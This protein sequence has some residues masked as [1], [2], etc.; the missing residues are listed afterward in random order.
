M[1]IILDEDVNVTVL[2]IDGRLRFHEDLNVTLR[3]NHI[4][5]RKGELLIGEATKPFQ[6]K[7]AIELYGVSSSSGSTRNLL[8]EAGDRALVN[9]GLIEFYGK[10]VANTLTRLQTTAEAGAVTIQV[11]SSEISGWKVGDYIGVAGS[12][13]S[14]D[15]QEIVQ[16]TGIAAGGI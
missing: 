12:S 10:V 13:F 3:A 11:N 15:Q 4:Y 1:N 8:I 2:I 7:A 6:N 5:V 14:H 9:T 16:I